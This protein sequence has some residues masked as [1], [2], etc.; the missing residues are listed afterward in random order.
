MHTTA[1]RASATCHSQT[2]A[3]A[4]TVCSRGGGVFCCPCLRLQQQRHTNAALGSGAPGRVDTWQAW[5]DV[6]PVAS[7]AALQQMLTLGT[8]TLGPAAV[9]GNAM[10][11]LACLPAG[12][13]Q[14]P[15]TGGPPLRQGAAAGL[16]PTHTYLFFSFEGGGGQVW[17]HALL[18]S[19]ISVAGVV[20]CT[21]R[22]L[23][24]RVVVVVV[25]C[26]PWLYPAAGTVHTC[27][28][29]ALLLLP[30]VVMCLVW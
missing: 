19:V 14:L 23:P 26:V 27:G 3:P 28:Q 17:Q 30:G 2:S 4:V 6:L 12:P 15:Q 25:V 1:G 18:P 16:S 13:Q 9:Q 20:A 5:R 10:P 21:W 22:H 7:W 29:P 8:A 11:C 24:V